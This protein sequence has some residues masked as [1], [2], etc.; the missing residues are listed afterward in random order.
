[1]NY[2]VCKFSALLVPSG[3]SLV[4][5]ARHLYCK[6]TGILIYLSSLWKARDIT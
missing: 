6:S 1:M 3:C 5:I 2:I 4:D